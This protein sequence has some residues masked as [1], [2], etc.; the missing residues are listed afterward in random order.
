VDLDGTATLSKEVVLRLGEPD[1]LKLFAPYPNPASGAA[2]L[3][4]A[5][6]TATDA[7]IEV[8][9]VL[10]QRVA[11]L[12]SGP[13]AAGR[14]GQRLNTSRWPSGLYFVRLQAGGGVKTQRLVVV[15]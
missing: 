12:D 4:Y 2:T 9:N 8:Y 1:R 15:R 13:Q 10:G 6:P 3:R 14:V 5:L 11:T 7:R